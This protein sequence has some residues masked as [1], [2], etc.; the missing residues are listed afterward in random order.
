MSFTQYVY[1]RQAAK[2]PQG[3]FIRDVWI[4]WALP[5]VRSWPELRDYLNSVGAYPSAIKAARSVWDSYRGKMRK[6]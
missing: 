5:E 2:S 1:Q 6:R 4:D 3:D